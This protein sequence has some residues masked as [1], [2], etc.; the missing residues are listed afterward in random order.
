MGRRYQLPPLP[1]SASRKIVTLDEPNKVPIG[2]KFFGDECCHMDIRWKFMLF[3]IKSY[4]LLHTITILGE[5]KKKSLNIKYTI[6]AITLLFIVIF[7][8]DLFNM[9][10]FHYA[11][12]TESSRV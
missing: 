12:L 7:W 10:T 1:P 6:T 4:N 9:I 8:W 5:T 11:H 2:L 3:D